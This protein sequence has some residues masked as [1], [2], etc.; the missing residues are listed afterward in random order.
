MGKEG[1]GR[2][3]QAVRVPGSRRD[4]RARLHLGRERGLATGST[5]MGSRSSVLIVLPWV[6][7]E[8]NPDR[9]SLRLRRC[10]WGFSGLALKVLGP[11]PWLVWLS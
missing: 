5:G 6:G 9:L 1:G 3:G 2:K 11:G 7:L 10:A 4:L 8:P